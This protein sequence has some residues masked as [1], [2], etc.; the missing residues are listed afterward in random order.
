MIRHARRHHVEEEAKAMKNP[1]HASDLSPR[2]G[3]AA[4]HP[5]NKILKLA[6]QLRSTEYTMA[7]EFMIRT[8]RLGR[9]YKSNLF[10]KTPTK[11]ASRKLR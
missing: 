2:N 7:K 10:G 4:F 11:P 5:G 1:W 9:R 6:H 8:Y 3:F